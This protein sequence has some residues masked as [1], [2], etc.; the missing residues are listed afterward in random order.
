[1]GKKHE[2]TRLTGSSWKACI[3]I[4]VQNMFVGRPCK[5]GESHGEGSLTQVMTY[6]RTNYTAV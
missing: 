4:Y 5:L 2:I 1:M 3:C 6:M